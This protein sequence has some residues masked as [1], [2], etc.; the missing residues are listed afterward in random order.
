MTTDHDLVEP[1]ARTARLWLRTVATHLDTR[2]QHAAYRALRAWLHA[3]RDRLG[4]AST[5]HLGAQLP[6]LLRGVHYDGWR[7]THVPEHCGATEFIA[8]FAHEAHIDIADVPSSAAAVTAALRDL[9]SPGQIDQVLAI[10]PRTILGVVDVQSHPVAAG[11]LEDRVADLE[12]TVTALSDALRTLAH[13]LAESP[14]AEPATERTAD[15][16]RQARHL[17]L[18]HRG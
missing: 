13:G 4:V 3:V 8:Q 11:R 16:A 5:A 2:D 17:L 10:L 9:C 1:A 12:T 15:A 6:D 14:I 18:T 7:P